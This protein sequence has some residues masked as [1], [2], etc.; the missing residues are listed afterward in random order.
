M[1]YQHCMFLRMYM[2]I[3][4][5][6]LCNTCCL[7]VPANIYY[8]YI[9]IDC[10]PTYRKYW[11]NIHMYILVHDHSSTLSITIYLYLA[12]SSKY[13]LPCILSMIYTQYSVGM[14]QY[15]NISIYCNIYYCNTIQYGIMEKSIYC[16]LQYIVIYCNIL[17]CL[18]S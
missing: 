2:Y 14:Q 16:T 15:Y 1:L 7:Y 3:H 10:K 11:M 5:C 6:K 9:H 8:I 18:L 13:M 12:S 17:Q 4:R